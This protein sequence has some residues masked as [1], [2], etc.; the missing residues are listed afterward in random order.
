HAPALRFLLRV[1]AGRGCDG[2]PG[3]GPP[4][5][6]GDRPSRPRAQSGLRRPPRGG[7]AAESRGHECPRAVK[8]A[9]PKG[10]TRRCL[11]SVVTGK[12]KRVERKVVLAGVADRPTPSPAYYSRRRSPVSV[13]G[14]FSGGAEPC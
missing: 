12:S 1:Q 5:H 14:T 10:R 13:L 11:A 2:V 9:A 3:P 7:D 4:G 8:G 6:G